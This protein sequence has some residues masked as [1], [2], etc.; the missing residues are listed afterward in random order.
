MIY[1]PVN[2]SGASNSQLLSL[3][4]IH[5]LTDLA[6]EGGRK[7]KFILAVPARRYGDLVETFQGSGCGRPTLKGIV[8]GLVAHDAARS[9][10]QS[11]ARRKRTGELEA[12]GNAMVT[13]LDAQ[14]QGKSALGRRASDR[15]P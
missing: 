5:H 9:L 11:D 14:D 4:N 8:S 15:E 1:R 12:M 10:E 13:K 7:L 3:D 2:H 6:D